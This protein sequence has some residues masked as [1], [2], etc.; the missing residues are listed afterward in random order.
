MDIY[1][2]SDE[3][4]VFDKNHNDT[5]VFGGLI[6]LGKFSKEEWSRRYSAAERTLRKS[7]GVSEDYELKASLVTNSEKG[8]LFRSLN[9]C[10]KFG[11]VVDESRV[12]DSIFSSK[13]SKQRYLDYVFKIAIKRAFED[14]IVKNIIQPNTIKRIHFYVDEHTTSTDGCYELREGLEEEF[15]YGTHNW[16]YNKFFP[17]I[18]MGLDEV[19]LKFCNSR[20]KLLIRAADIIANRIYRLATNDRYEDLLK[21]HKLKIIRLP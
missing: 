13:K 20:T 18:F 2:Y 5:F 1:V 7:K 14:L 16:N 15:K 8:K 17:P 10:Y 19:R 21:I 9:Q 3:S 6:L 11:V 12:L 4:G